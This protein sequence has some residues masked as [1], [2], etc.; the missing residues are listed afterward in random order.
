M[1]EFVF[2][3]LVNRKGSSAVKWDWAERLTGKKELLPFWVADMD[4]PVAPPIAEALKRRVD[5]GIFGYSATPPGV[6]EAFISWSNRRFGWKIAEDDL[7][8][9]G[10]VVPTLHLIVQEWT[11]EGDTVV[12]QEPVYYPFRQAVERNGRVVAVNPLIEGSSGRL[13]MDPAG[14]D[15][16]FRKTGSRL[17]F[18]C[19]PHNPVGRVWSREELEDIASVCRKYGV[20]VI[21]DEIHADIVFPGHRHLPWPTVDPATAE[22]SITLVS[23]TKSFNIPGLPFAYAVIPNGNFRSRLRSARTKIGK[24]HGEGAALS[25]AAAE[26]AWRFGEPWLE[27]LMVYLREN[28]LMVKKTLAEK[29]PQ[30]SSTPLEGT[31]LEWLDCRRL[32]FDDDELRRRLLE[33]GV[34]L[35]PGRDFGVGGSGHMRFNIAAPKT[36]IERG[37]AGIVA[38]FR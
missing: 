37:L 28:D 27:A 3:T 9:I 34:W 29:L 22:E 33:K 18:L 4:F 2:D 31:Y 15:E 23:P 12:I 24:P 25:H 38:A 13:E 21:S 30:I 19:S 14:L 8:E 36:L 6:G 26:A 5:H 16:V 7:V 20:T 11:E 32:G 1:G 10:G 17:L 35:S